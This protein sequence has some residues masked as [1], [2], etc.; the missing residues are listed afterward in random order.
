MITEPEAVLA[1]S[2]ITGVCAVAAGVGLAVATGRAA[3]RT[4]RDT[5]RRTAY[6]QLLAASAT[7]PHTAHTLRLTR[8]LRTGL[9]DAAMHLRPIDIGDLD[10]L[11]WRDAE[12]MHQAWSAVWVVGTQEAIRLANDLVTKITD[13]LEGATRPGQARTGIVRYLAGEKWS[14]EQLEAWNG[15]VAA[16]AQARRAFALHARHELGVEIAEVFLVAPQA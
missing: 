15:Q 10:A 3:R 1:A 7:V 16:M 14:E 11:L 6:S 9:K 12:P 13:V 5:R 8:E 2:A 4:E